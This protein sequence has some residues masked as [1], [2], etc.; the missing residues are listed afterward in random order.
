MT[1]SSP[2]VYSRVSYSSLRVCMS[3]SDAFTCPVARRSVIG[4]GTAHPSTIGKKR[5]AERLQRSR[6]KRAPKDNT[7]A[8]LRV[9]LL[10]V[11]G[12]TCALV[13]LTKL[14]LGL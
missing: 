14:A 12:F 2:G 4:E 7:P 6:N 13:L 10:V 3:G 1:H 8:D 5:R 11:A 9:V